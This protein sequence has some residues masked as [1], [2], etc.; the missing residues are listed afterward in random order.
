MSSFDN[1]PF[2]Y[3]L[4]ALTPKSTWAS[5]VVTMGNGSEQRAVLWTDA[6]RR[7]DAST[8]PTMTLAVLQA[9]EKHFNGRKG[10]GRS[11]P[12]RDRSAFRGT[13]ETIGTGDGSTTV[14]Q[15]TVASG[16]SGNAYGR[17]IYLPESGTLSVFDNGTPVVEGAGAGKF[18]AV[19]AGGGANGG[20]VTFGTA[21]VNTHII[22]ATFDYWI[23]V[24]YDLD[25]FPD[26]R[27]FVWVTGTQGLVS[28]P[29]LP[30]IEVRYTD[31]TF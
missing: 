23:P 31:E 12:L 6:R 15:L 17:E 21:P 16:D 22:T 28:G 18:T 14:F 27:L 10:R 1:T 24:R 8:Q 5:T 11:F 4:A 13:A 25:E 7:Y 19:Y 20:K 30:M 2:P 29:S 26:A 9:I 3:E